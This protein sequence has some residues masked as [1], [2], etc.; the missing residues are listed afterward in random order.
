MSVNR[1]EYLDII[2]IVSHLARSDGDIADSE[3]KSIDDPVQ[4]NRGHE[5]RAG[6]DESQDLNWV[7]IGGNSV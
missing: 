6:C 4:G 1:Q 7:V 5:G 2:S 3:K